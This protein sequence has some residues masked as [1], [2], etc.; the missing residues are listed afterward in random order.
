MDKV[1][2]L[3]LHA[4]YPSLILYFIYVFAKAFVD[5]LTKRDICN[6]AGPA[7]VLFFVVFIIGVVGYVVTLLSK[8]HGMDK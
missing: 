6:V 2:K 4:I 3:F 8:K 7:A 5:G 1:F